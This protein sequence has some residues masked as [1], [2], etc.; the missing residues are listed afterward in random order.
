[1]IRLFP[2]LLLFLASGCLSIPPRPPSVRYTRGQNLVN[3]SFDQTGGW[4][5]YVTDE[6]QIRREEGVYRMLLDRKAYIWGMNKGYPTRQGVVIEVETEQISTYNANAYGIICRADVRNN[7]G[8]YYFL[9]SGDGQYSIRWGDGYAVNPLVEFGNSSPT[10][11]RGQSKNTIRAVCIE[12]YLALFVNGEFLTEV[13]DDRI[14]SG[15]YVGLTVVVP[16]N[17]GNIDLAFDKLRIWES[18][19][20]NPGD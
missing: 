3:E 20:I 6:A 14:H 18:E 11:H 8:G 9:I 17:V 19:I 16:N 2:L 5:T 13:R 15:G 4:T 10:I 7:S 12:D 1:M